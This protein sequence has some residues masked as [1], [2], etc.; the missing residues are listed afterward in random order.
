MA[1]GSASAN[2][3]CIAADGTVFGPGS[4]VT[5]SCTFNAS[6]TCTDD[7]MP[8]LYI[9][10]D[11]IVIDGNG[12]AMTG[13]RSAT[14]CG[15][16]VFGPIPGEMA[17]AKHSGIVNGANMQSYDNVVIQNL[18]IVNFCTG[19]VLGDGVIFCR[20]RQRHGGRLSN[21]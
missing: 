10:A 7:A 6:M 4:T 20:C 1:A 5:E 13:S 17:P 16:A 2:G 15:L 18:E 21:I 3:A 8:G 19:I 14:A 11:D 12:Y 9:G